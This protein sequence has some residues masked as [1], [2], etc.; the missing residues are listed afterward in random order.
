MKPAASSASSSSSMVQPH[1]LA[2][3]DSPSERKLIERIFQASSFKVTVADSGPRALELLDNME[4]KVD[5]IVTDYCMPEMT[6]YE[7]LKKV[8]ESPK[9]KDIPVVI[10]SSENL[11]RRVNECLE[12]GARDFL[13][14][15]F[16]ISDVEKIMT[17]LK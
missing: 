1:V 9:L 5:L 6:G 3:D 12:G 4:G 11:P 15:P 17:Y 8:K 10:L 16:Q 7:L 14:K 13:F 2:V